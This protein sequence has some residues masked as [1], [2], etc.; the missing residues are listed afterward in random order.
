MWLV[1]T[2]V[3]GLKGTSFAD[4]IG[5]CFA[6]QPMVPSLSFSN[7]CLRVC[8]RMR[9]RTCQSTEGG[10]GQTHARH[11]SVERWER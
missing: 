9:V 8:E 5:Q 7:S 1:K 4:G 6:F 3:L 2:R 11:Q 10:G